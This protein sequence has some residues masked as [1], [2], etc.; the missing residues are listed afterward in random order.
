MKNLLWEY[1]E[2]GIKDAGLNVL[3]LAHKL[4]IAPSVLYKTKYSKTLPNDATLEKISKALDLDIETI[5]ELR[6][7]SPLYIRSKSARGKANRR[8]KSVT[9]ICK[10]CRKRGVAKK[11]WTKYPHEKCRKA[12]QLQCKRIVEKK[13]KAVHGQNR[14]KHLFGRME[15]N[16]VLRE[17]KKLQRQRICL[18][19]DKPFNSRGPHNRI[20]PRCTSSRGEDIFHDIPVY[21]TTP[22]RQ[23]AI[24][25]I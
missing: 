13:F 12:A 8:N 21:K 9:V 1:I 16:N 20:C 14:I 15:Q 4:H 24:N 7:L 19:C 10:R 23:H 5:I 3:S 22:M 17:E 2:T 18:R 25:T 11:A 6:G